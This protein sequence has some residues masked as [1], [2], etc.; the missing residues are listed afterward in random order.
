M[1]KDDKKKTVIPT[2]KSYGFKKGRQKTGGRQKGTK[3]KVTKNVRRI[4]EEQL[5]PKLEKIGEIIDKIQAPEDKAA[6][7]AHFLPFVAPRY[8][9]T[10]FNTDTKRD[11]TTEE[12]IKDLNGKYDKADITIDISSV[13]IINNG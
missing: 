8:S 1:A 2:E 3:N 13:K 6:A 11:I 9:N 5:M 7:I 4:L 12:Y 10:T